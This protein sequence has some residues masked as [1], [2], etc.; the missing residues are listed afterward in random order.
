MKEN[1]TY[2]YLNILEIDE[3]EEE[4]NSYFQRIKDNQV[5][6]NVNKDNA[7]IMELNLDSSKQVDGVGHLTKYT[8]VHVDINETMN[9]LP[10]LNK[11]FKK[12]GL[13]E[14]SRIAIITTKPNSVQDPHVDQGEE[15]LGI[16]FPLAGTSAT[17]TQI[18]KNKGELK[19][20][21]SPDEEII[22]GQTKARQYLKY[23]DDNP[24]EIGRY[25]LN[26]PV[27]LNVKMP[28]SVVNLSNDPRVGI[29]FRF[30]ADP[31]ELM[32]MTTEEY[33]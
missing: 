28:H 4:L 32:D 11:F 18:F 5:F 17:Y 12:M 13:S 24:E 22:P 2:R 33:I 1:F 7:P 25:E 23:I 29:S 9:Q 31:W 30:N 27:I 8:F 20:V 16:N 19:Y 3:I 6:R 15:T 26:R 14:L 10:L 21:S